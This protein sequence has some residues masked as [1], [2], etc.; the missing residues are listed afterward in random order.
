MVKN[1]INEFTFTVIS[2]EIKEKVLAEML[3]VQ[4]LI[5]DSTS[6]TVSFEIKEKALLEV[7]IQ[8]DLKSLK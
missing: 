8:S 4:N 5:N 3:A 7:N 6:T 1:P 2:L